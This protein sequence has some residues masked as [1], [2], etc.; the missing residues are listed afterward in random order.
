MFLVYFGRIQLFSQDF[1]SERFYVSMDVNGCQYISKVL[2]QYE[3]E[4]NTIA[5]K[6]ITACIYRP[7]T[8]A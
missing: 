8:L 1:G 5:V 3:F 4:F 6:C 2:F 7:V